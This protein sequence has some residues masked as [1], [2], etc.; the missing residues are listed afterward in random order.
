MKQDLLYKITQNTHLQGPYY[1]LSISGFPASRP[2][3][4]VNIRCQEDSRFL[5]RRPF[6]INRITEDETYILYKVVGQGTELLSQRKAGELLDVIGPLGRGWG[7]KVESY[8]VVEPKAPTTPPNDKQIHVLVG[9]GVGAAPLLGL[10]E[11]IIATRADD[12][13]MVLLGGRTQADI[14]C[15]QDFRA[16]GCEVSIATD[17]GSYGQRG[18]VTD[19]LLS[20]QKSRVSMPDAQIFMYTCGPKPMMA[21][22]AKIAKESGTLCQVSLEETMGCGL[23]GCVCCVCETKDGYKKICAEGP[24]FSAEEI[25]W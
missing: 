12:M 17:D 4:F 22:V 18:L 20:F 8:K 5:L 23:G 10:A 9:G 21:A 11:D 1:L 19:L 2:G 15:E 16:L 25:V 14:L 3:Q 24:V 6:S 13:V 7:F